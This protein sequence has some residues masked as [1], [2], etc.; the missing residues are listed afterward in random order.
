MQGRKELLMNPK[1]IIFDCDGTIVDSEPLTNKVVA[2]MAGELGI[3][4]TE[5]E[6][7][8]LYTSPSPRD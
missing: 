2:E 5:D 4:M 1:C 6:A 7:C 3:K 8:L